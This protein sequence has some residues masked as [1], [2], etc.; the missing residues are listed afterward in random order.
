MSQAFGIKS[1]RAL[2]VIVAVAPA[3]L[4]GP[5]RAQPAPTP[6]VA[7]TQFVPP[8]TAPTPRPRPGGTPTDVE[9]SAPPVA[10]PPN[11]APLPKPPST[12]GAAVPKPAT[13][14]VAPKPAHASAPWYDKLRVRGYTQ[15]RYNRLLA[16][17]D[18]FVNAQG[19]R[20]IGKL[21]GFS[22]R[23]ARLIVSGDVHERVSVYLQTDAANAVGDLTHVVAMR[24]WYADVA[25]DERK[26]ARFRLGQ[27]KVPYGFENM[28]SSQNRTP[29]DRSDAINTGAPNERDLGVFFY[30]APAEIRARFKHLVDSGLKGSGDY[31]VIALGAY[32]GQ[33]TNL[34]ER[35]DNL[36]VIARATYPFVIGDQIL[37][38]GGGGYAGKYVVN[39]GDETGGPDE[40]RDA[41]AHV[42][43]TLYPQ[44]FGFQA[45]YNVGVGPELDASR[46]LVRE[47]RP[48]GGYAMVMLRLGHFLPYARVLTY[49]G[50]KKQ[51]TDAIKYKVR[52]LEAGLE[53]RVF[54][55]LELTAAFTQ[56]S[57]TAPKSPYELESGRLVRLQAQF[58]Y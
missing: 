46:N 39:K 57:R 29:L 41:R 22:L 51:E 36:H 5:A 26:E 40:F 53:W 10:L 27:S 11:A 16:S 8:A 32:N 9:P 12:P 14:E 1:R 18:D 43:V 13:P 37:E 19:D 17:N 31:G 24:D 56:G 35:N 3:L 6:A 15:L 21:N 20:S 55:A 23:R 25:L 45:E 38:L 2:A 42:A 58:N 50:G 34:K 30:W 54:D 7:Q 48:H 33:G 4:A 52:E 28:Q 47:G 49:D 44:P